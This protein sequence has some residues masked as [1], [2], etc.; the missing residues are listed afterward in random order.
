M[1]ILEGGRTNTYDSKI[2]YKQR[3]ERDPLS[4]ILGYTDYLWELQKLRDA[5]MHKE[6][7]PSPYYIPFDEYSKPEK[8][9]MDIV[10]YMVQTTSKPT[11]TS[12]IFRES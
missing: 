6:K 5:D 3:F 9:N 10:C 8:A 7:S 2:C 1:I 4:E 11:T 12:K